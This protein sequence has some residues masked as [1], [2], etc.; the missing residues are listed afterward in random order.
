M[1]PAKLKT[2]PEKWLSLKVRLNFGKKVLEIKCYKSLFY[3]S[4]GGKIR[5]ADELVQN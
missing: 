5:P 3:M 1:E 2:V 4:S